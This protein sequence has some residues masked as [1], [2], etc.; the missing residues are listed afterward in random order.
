MEKKTFTPGPWEACEHSWSDTSVTAKDKTLF[1]MSIYDEATEETQEEL[2]AQMNADARFIAC[3]P[4][5]F[6][7]LAIMTSLVRIKYGNLDKDVYAQIEK[8]EALLTKA[9]GQ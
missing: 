1:T 7:Q 4:D 6:E 9:S 5:L 3:A 2:E 8:A